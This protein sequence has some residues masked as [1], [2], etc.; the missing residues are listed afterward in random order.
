MSLSPIRNSNVIPMM[1]L[2]RLYFHFPDFFNSGH[3]GWTYA[4]SPVCSEQ[5]EEETAGRPERSI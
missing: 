3:S 5:G 1:L 2:I 4:V